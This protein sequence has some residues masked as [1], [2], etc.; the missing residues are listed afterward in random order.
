MIVFTVLGFVSFWCFYL[1]LCPYIKAKYWNFNGDLCF[2]YWSSFEPLGGLVLNI[3]WKSGN[4][5]GNI[6]FNWIGFMLLRYLSWSVVW[7][8]YYRMPMSH[9][10][11]D[12]YIYFISTFKGQVYG[13]CLGDIVTLC[14]TLLYGMWW[15][16]NLV[17]W[18]PDRILVNDYETVVMFWNKSGLS[19]I[20]KE[21]NR[22][23]LRRSLQQI[24]SLWS[25]DWI[26]L[27]STACR[28]W[29]RW[30]FRLQYKL[31]IVAFILVHF[32]VEGKVHYGVIFQRS[33]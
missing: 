28:N 12:I 11:Y 15:D 14:E 32:P 25:I 24:I 10:T 9:I 16:A 30:R 5:H 13:K 19:G 27:I 18:F 26:W 20:C 22:R 17:F 33:V 8:V 31:I 7:W 23:C 1:R 29:I 21:C 6:G 2:W 3:Y 4:G